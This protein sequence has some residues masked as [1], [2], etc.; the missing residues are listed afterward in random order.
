M[1]VDTKRDEV[2]AFQLLVN[3]HLWKERGPKPSED[4]A[5]ARLGVVELHQDARRRA[6]GREVLSRD[7]VE[8]RG[9]IA[10]DETGACKVLDRDAAVSRE[11]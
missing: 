11:A 3:R 9:G 10:H 1:P 5:F 6:R 2:T 8:I 4:D 7:R